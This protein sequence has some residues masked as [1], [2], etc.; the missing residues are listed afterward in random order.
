MI[1]RRIVQNSLLAVATF[2]CT[3]VA[4]RAEQSDLLLIEAEVTP[5]EVWLHAQAQYKLRLLQAVP[6]ND[7]TLVGPDT[8]LAE[9]RPLGP[10]QVSETTRNGIRYR[11]T[12]RRF[13]LFPFTSGTLE[14]KGAHL[15]AQSPGANGITR[16]RR[17]AIR[18]DA[19]PL[20]LTVRAA[21]AAIGSAHWLPAHDV[22]ISEV[23]ATAPTTVQQG[24][25]MTRILRL[26]AH[27]VDAARLPALQIDTE[28]A[29]IHA[30]PARLSN[31]IE[32]GV[33][34][35]LREQRFDILPRNAGTLVLP[36]I[37]VGWWN[38]DTNRSERSILDDRELIVE[39]GTASPDAPAKTPSLPD[40]LSIPAAPHVETPASETSAAQARFSPVSLMLGTL[41]ITLAV[42]AAASRRTASKRALA[43]IRST[44]RL[45]R[46]C[47]NGSASATRDALI[48]WANAHGMPTA[49]NLCAISAGLKGKHTAV[50]VARLDR[51]LYGCDGTNWNGK[52]LLAALRRDRL[53]RFPYRA[54]IPLASHPHDPKG[55]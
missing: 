14:L 40:Q 38:I 5:S 15:E 54:G 36:T 51:H 39:P 33:N 28:D 1:V 18:L 21:P 50:E 46:S 34:I 3:A 55:L 27:G 7:L 41:A 44:S 37:E 42:F 30:H 2:A 12:E 4:A 31:R 6:L 16:Q 29:T 35:G 45:R 26:E 10:D 53:I 22:N 23:G 13:A 9:M 25:P 47:L 8:P 49:Q 17:P 11:V 48:N 43:R 20:A 32:N 52:N 24:N 19:A